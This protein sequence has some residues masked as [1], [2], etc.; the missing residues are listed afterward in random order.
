MSALATLTASAVCRV[1]GDEQVD[2]Q[3]RLKD[4]KIFQL[5]QQTATQ[6]QR[7]EELKYE[8]YDLRSRVSQAPIKEGT[9]IVGLDHWCANKWVL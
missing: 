3:I 2:E 1:L 8:N 4:D 9:C 6:Q 5:K 7:I